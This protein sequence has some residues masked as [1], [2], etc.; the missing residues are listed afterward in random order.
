MPARLRLYVYSVILL[1][2]SVVA[3]GVPKAMDHPTDAWR[4]VL[5][6]AIFLLGDSAVLHLRFGRDRYSFTWSEVAVVVG[7]ALL[8]HG[9]L[10]LAAFVGVG[11]AHALARRAPVKVLFNAAAFAIG[12]ALTRMVVQAS[13]IDVSSPE[14]ADAWGILAVGSFVFFLWNTL[15]VAGAVALSQK[16]SIFSVLDRGLAL[17]AVVWLGNTAIGVLVVALAALQPAALLVFPFLLGAL[18]GLYRGYLRAIHENDVW[19]VLQEAS[20]NLLRTDRAE[21]GRIVCDSSSTLLGGEFVELVL[22]GGVEGQRGSRYRLFEDGHFE[23]RSGDLHDLAG[24]YWGRV[25]CDREPFELTTGNA[26]ASQRSEMETLGVKQCLVAPLIVDKRCLGALRVGFA[27]SGTIKGRDLQVFTTFANSV[28]AA[29]HN[30]SLFDEVRERALRDPLTG[31]P[32]RALIE[33][34]L[35]QAITRADRTGGR[36]AVLFLDLDRFKVIN[37]SLG[38][39]VGDDLLV[40]VS[41]RV[42]S[43]LRGSDTAGRF[44]GDEF[45][46]LCEDIA[47]EE[48][49]VDV[50]QRVVDAF[51]E[52]F[53]LQGEN[54]FLSASVGI[55]VASGG[56]CTATA[57]VRDADAAMYR[58]KERGRNR[59]EMFDSEM[60]SMAVSRLEIER[61]LRHALDRDE[62]ELHFQ[63][64]VDIATQ[65]V[66]GAE[67]LLRWKREDGSFV[68][69]DSFIRI[70]EE[71]GMIRSIG[72]W[73]LEDACLQLAKWKRMLGDDRRFTLAVNLSAHQIADSR[74]VDEVANV[75][76][77]TNVAPESLCLEITESALLH[78]LDAAL[79]IVGKLRG[80]GVRVALDDFGTGYSS[81]RYLQQLPVDVLKI[82]RSFISRIGPASRD[83]S[84]VARMIDLAHALDLEVVAE[85]VETPAQLAELASMNCEVAQGFYF[86]APQTADAFTRMLDDEIVVDIAASTI[87]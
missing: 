50:A 8:P 66:I 49:V 48:V 59:F 79:D 9:W 76:R 74:I 36:V 67:A 57:L 58:A 71:T 26:P 4:V 37:D 24:T 70:A 38:H 51:A 2:F 16:V 78:D 23:E 32:N 30:A 13:G 39:Q 1:G 19:V 5:A 25:I 41:S 63:P 17:K 40:S 75:L 14:H 47:N 64:T 18:Y 65:R 81:L 44:G 85:G 35:Q 55:A 60:R 33:D 86:S 80:L 73:A 20:R 10:R 61:S 87:I 62:L 22:A 21:L 53:K 15:S 6:A 45:V 54:V 31:L 52:P 84:I 34:R 29:A 68:G 27:N 46:I 7:L 11:L 43:V 12:T 3:V 42:R 83:S 72:A 28:S 56:T 69:P 82:D 77:M